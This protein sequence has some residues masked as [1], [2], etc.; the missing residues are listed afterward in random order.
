M[1]RFNVLI[2]NAFKYQTFAT[3]IEKLSWFIKTSHCDVRLCNLRYSLPNQ[4]KPKLTQATK[5]KHKQDHMTFKQ[6]LS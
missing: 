4:S 2:P 1:I 3:K 6:W 5:Y